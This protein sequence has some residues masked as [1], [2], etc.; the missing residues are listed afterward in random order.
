MTGLEFA[1]NLRYAHFD[2]NEISDLEPLSRLTDLSTLSLSDNEISDLAPLSRLTE[3]DVLNLNGND[4]SDISSL[5]H[6]IE[7]EE[8]KLS[9]NSVSDLSPLSRMMYLSRLDLDGNLV[10]DLSPLE[11]L[12]SLDELY[13]SNNQLS[14]LVALERLV[15]LRALNLSNNRFSDV[16][17][18]SYLVDLRWLNLARNQITDL[19]PL[20][21]LDDLEW[22]WLSDNEISD[23]SSLSYLDQLVTLDLSR[24]NVTDIAPLARLERLVYAYISENGVSNLSPLAGLINLVT[25]DLSRNQIAE[26]NQVSNLANLVLLNLS[27]NQISDLSPVA[28]LGWLATLELSGNA[29]ADLA[30][31]T[32]D[33]EFGRRRT[34]VVLRDNPISPDAMNTQIPALENRGVVVLHRDPHVPLFP[35]TSDPRREGFVRITN[36]GFESARIPIRATDDAGNTQDRL[37]LVVGAGETVHFNSRDLEF[38]NSSKGLN[39]SAGTGVGDWRLGFERVTGAQVDVLGYIRT[40]DGFLTT[41][42]DLVPRRG[43]SLAVATFNPGSNQNQVSHLRLINPNSTAAEVTV[44]GIDDRGVASSGMVSLAL[45]PGSARTISARQLERGHSGLRGA[46]GDGAGKWRLKISSNR[47]IQAMNLL[48]TPAGHLTNLSTV[49]WR[50]SDE[51]FVS[52]FP[53]ASDKFRRQGFVRVINRSSESGDVQIEVADDS[54]RRYEL[55]SLSMSAEEAVQFNSDDLELGNPSKGLSAGVGPG[56]GD[57]R[58]RLRS[59][60]LDIEVLAYIRTEDGFLTAMHDVLPHA[61]WRYQRVATFNPGS[62]PNQVSSLRLVNPDWQSLSGAS[63]AITGTDDN[64]VLMGEMS[65][66]VFSSEPQTVTAE[67]LE[68]YLGDGA[69]KWRLSILSDRPVRAMSLL[70]SP[71]GHLTN[72]STAPNRP[73]VL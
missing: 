35:S 66:T 67:Q 16:S 70:S 62:N 20:S 8:L 55:L 14:D 19:S 27:D 1:R 71:T 39:G 38:G 34:F 73:F 10:S 72:L 69:G 23:V 53:S 52:L 5:S 2:R 18:L 41:M 59:T 54:S 58:L 17:S 32:A 11:P 49:P 33:T 6:L 50:P 28:G 13:L 45:P 44:E 63:V 36:L 61:H 21:Y 24:N 15:E 4:V 43:L 37:S 12:T 26:I 47:R 51:H 42:H 48:E 60:S 46:L 65:V 31:L 29:I 3:L 64:G 68:H 9:G 25:L 57:W 40:E 56:I 7:I 22:L 30:P